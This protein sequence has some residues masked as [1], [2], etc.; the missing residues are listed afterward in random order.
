[1]ENTRTTD[2]QESA[3]Y[4]PQCG[5]CG[6]V[7]ADDQAMWTWGRGAVAH[8]GCL[9]LEPPSREG[10]EPRLVVRGASRRDRQRVFVERQR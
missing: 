8:S 9:Q 2:R 5:V 4:R 3:D 6:D 7:I 10:R 1:M